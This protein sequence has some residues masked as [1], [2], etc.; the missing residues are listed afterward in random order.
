[1]RKHQDLR[2]GS[3]F[4]RGWDVDGVCLHGSPL[5]WG[6]FH[7]LGWLL[8]GVDGS[9]VSFTSATEPVLRRHLAE[10]QSPET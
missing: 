4:T 6:F 3:G 9:V 2:Y 7:S 1:M 5:L 10:P 8:S